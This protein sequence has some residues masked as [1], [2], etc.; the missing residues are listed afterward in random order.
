MITTFLPIFSNN[1]RFNIGNFKYWAILWLISV[2]LLAP[3]V[4]NNKFFLYVLLHWIILI[5]ILLNSLWVNVNDWNK[6]LAQG[7]VLEFLV[8]ISLYAYFTL[9]KD[10]EGLAMLVK[11]TLIFVAIT[12]IMTIYSSTIDPFYARKIVGGEYTEAETA[13]IVR[14]GGGGMDFQEL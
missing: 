8:P 11:W 7:E 3:R 6:K 10:F 4:F 5:F 9:S 14:Y 12:A 1:V 2:I 13:T